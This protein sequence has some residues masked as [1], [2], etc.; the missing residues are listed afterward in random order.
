VDGP[1]KDR[2]VANV[3]RRK[4]DGYEPTP[5]GLAAIPTSDPC[6]RRCPHCGGPLAVVLT[7]PKGNPPTAMPADPQT[8]ALIPKQATLGPRP[9]PRQV[10]TRKVMRRRD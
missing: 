7:I 3:A 4:G 1:A 2:V 5:I 10:E 9:D 8:Q 6:D